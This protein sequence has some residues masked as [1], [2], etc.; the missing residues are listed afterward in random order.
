MIDK[1]IFIRKS[2]FRLAG[3]TLLFLVLI[4]GFSFIGYTQNNSK[5]LLV[6]TDL[7]KCDD[8]CKKDTKAFRSL[9]KSS[10]WDLGVFKDTISFT[11]YHRENMR[12]N[13]KNYCEQRKVSYYLTSQLIEIKT[14][15]SEVKYFIN[16][17]LFDLNNEIQENPKFEFEIDATRPGA[18]IDYIKKV[19]KEELEYFSENGDRFKPVVKVETFSPID[20]DHQTNHIK[21]FPEWMVIKL[22]E[23]RNTSLLYRFSYVDEEV[24]EN[25]DKNY[26]SGRL[27]LI[28]END[29]IKVI[30]WMNNSQNTADVIIYKDY[31][32]EDAKTRELIIKKVISILNKTQ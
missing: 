7:K 13:F 20:P 11:G 23:N 29:S 32:A 28:E 16:F 14:S 4:F 30:F 15:S 3:R 26:I 9:I 27:N 24:N 6:F 21:D 2:I 22:N 5:T 8:G 18:S 17:K 25:L 31:K 19:L 10:L 12:R 1:N